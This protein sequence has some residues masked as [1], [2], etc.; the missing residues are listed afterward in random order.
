MIKSKIKNLGTISEI[1][2]S[3]I[4]VKG[5]E[6]IVRLHD[7]I[8]VKK[9]NIIGE[10]IQIYSNRINIQCFENTEHLKLNE[11]VI[12]LE[13]PLSMELGPGLLSNVFDG[14]QRPLDKIYELEKSGF[15]KRGI[16]IPS[17]SRDKKWDFK[18]LK[19]IND[20]LNSGDVIG[21]VE[22]NPTISHYILVPPGIEGKLVYIREEGEYTVLEDL[23]KVNIKGNAQNFNMIQ[24]WP[25]TKNRPFYKKL[26]PKEPLITGQRILDLLFPIVK[27][28][29]V[30]VPGGFGTGKTVIQ[31]SLAK[32]CS[33]DIIIFIGCGERGNEIADV[34]QQFAKLIDPRSGRPLL[35]R[36]VLIAN[37]SNMPISARE[38]SIFSGITIAEYYRDMG[39]DVTLQADSTSRWAEALREISGL[40]EEMPAE[41]GYPA[42]L[43][44]RLSSFYERAGIIETLGKDNLKNNKIGSLTVIGSISPPAG[45]FSEPITSNTKRFVQTFWALDAELAYEKH[46]PAVNWLESYSNYPRYI[47]DW[48]SKIDLNWPEI[49]FDWFDC[50][51]QINEIL[52]R[53]NE[54]KNMTQLVGQENLPEEQQLDIFI[55]KI[56]KEAILIQNAFDDIDAFTGPIKMIA[57][58]KIILLL[59]RESKKLLEEDFYVKDIRGLNIIEEILRIKN[60]IPNEEVEK[61]GI[62]KDN[63]MNE[64]KSLKRIHGVIGK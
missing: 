57:L 23:Y 15:I 34:L 8:K 42:Y 9:Y 59:Y 20:I 33:A 28:G 21:I 1:N 49:E 13:E 3:L 51:A 7:L 53:E 56:I 24:K 5:L 25:V 54:L 18:P 14:I 37:T 63:L 17:L 38:S 19:K 64:L 50:R 41:G 6:K 47:R 39:Y 10:I 4:T 16:D 61:I 29:T 44:S 27:G 40:L 52:S 12:Y 62:I 45:D 26:I 36:I 48:W 31:Q 55:A 30:A 46:Y 60:T 35:E 43:P 32:W 11:K 22:E 2:G 58:I